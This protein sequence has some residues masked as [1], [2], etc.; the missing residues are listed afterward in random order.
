MSD[1]NDDFL[2]FEKALRELKLRS[3]ELRKLVSEGEIRARKD[4]DSMKFKKE[5]IAALAESLK[6]LPAE[7]REVFCL[8]Y[9]HGW[10]Q[11]QMAELLCVD[12]RTI[13]RYRT[14]AMISL[15]RKLGEGLPRGG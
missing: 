4:G 13:R 3:E 2:S 8:E 10:K 7:Q 14:D 5:D 1:K 15:Q 6:L 11:K 12:E 9:F